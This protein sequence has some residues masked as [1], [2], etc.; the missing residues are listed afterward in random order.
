MNMKKFFSK[1]NSQKGAVTIEAT[2]A[3]TAFLFMFIMVYSIITICRAQAKIQVSINSTA[4]EIS[5]YSYLYS[6]TGLNGPLGNLAESAEETR[7]DINELSGN[8]ADVFSGIQSIGGAVENFDGIEGVGDTW[9]QINAGLDTTEE[10]FAKA[11]ENVAEMAKDPKKML[12][13]MGKLLAT[14]GV[15]FVKSAAAEALSRALTEKHLKRSEKDT[16]EN[17]CKDMGVVPG[18]YIATTSY[19]NGI[20]F[21]HSKLFPYGSNE[22]IIVANYKMKL[23][24]LLSIPL[25]MHF[26]QTAVTRGWMQGDKEPTDQTTEKKIEEM[27]QKGDSLWNTMDSSDR[28]KMI[29]K[30][31]IADLQDQGYFGVSGQTYIHAYDS[32]TNTMALVR[33]YNPLAY[34]DSVDKVDKQKVKEYLEKVQGQ[35]TSTTDNMHTIKIK[36]QDANGNVTNSEVNCSGAKKLKAIIVIPEDAGLDTVFQQA[37]AEMGSGVEFEILPGYGKVYEDKTAEP[38][39][40]GEE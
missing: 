14:E 34:A 7:G 30:M 17:F 36:K 2:I 5:Q 39:T 26:T 33:S 4:K 15:E 35:L 16:A 8:V 28:E 23:L 12:F 20:D 21:S 29:R 11:R 25:E 6:L 9:E 13:G 37:I 32:S 3:L 1:K 18:K 40:G 10:G 31:G 27:V 38:A 24:Q 22:I 19:F